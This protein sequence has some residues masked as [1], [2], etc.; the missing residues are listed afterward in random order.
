MILAAANELGIPVTARGAG[1]GLS[2][3]CVPRPDGIVVS[4]ERM[5]LGVSIGKECSPLPCFTVRKCGELK[6]VTAIG[7]RVFISGVVGSDAVGSRSDP[8]P[9]GLIQETICLIFTGQIDAQTI[10]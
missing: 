3:A 8:S 6:P 1:T 7:A 5:N 9:N 2:G 4:F 10:I